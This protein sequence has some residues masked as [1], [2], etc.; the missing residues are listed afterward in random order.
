MG[1]RWGLFAASSAAEGH[2]AAGATVRAGRG[3]RASLFVRH[4]ATPPELEEVLVLRSSTTVGAQLAGKLDRRTRLTV[5]VFN[6]FD[7]RGGP[8]DYFT[9]ARI[10]SYRGSLDGYLFHPGEGRGLRITVS[11]GF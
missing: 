2:A 3:W 5:D 10:P 11:R 4:V 7:Q 6:V 9:T 8:V 1:A